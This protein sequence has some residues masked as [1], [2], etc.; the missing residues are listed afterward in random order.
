M[1]K[2]FFLIA[3]ILVSV[4][5]N[6]QKFAYINTQAIL[7][8][9]PEVQQAN[10]NLETFRNQLVNL[11]QMKLEAL[12]TKYKDLEAKQAKGELSPKQLED[13]SAK[14]KLDEEAL[15]KFDQE[16]Q[17]RVMEKSEELLK[18]IRDKVQKA[19]DDV[20]KEGGY[21]YVF[22]A[23]MGFILYADSSTDIGELVKTK[24]T[25]K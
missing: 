18:P 11:G 25:A 16:S 13:E 22:D 4:F 17:Q 7:G 3:F 15:N 14:L 23:S 20:A 1:K 8:N 10:S 6:A 21:Q 2:L 24:L 19:I 12:Q 5:S 9:M